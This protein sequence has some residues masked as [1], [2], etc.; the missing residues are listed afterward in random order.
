[1]PSTTSKTPNPLAVRL[2]AEDLAWLRA[3]RETN[4]VSV[5]SLISKAVA[6]Y[7]TRVEAARKGKATRGS[8][9]R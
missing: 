8:H 9:S 5:N 3:E 6:Q 1:M 2:D 7:R 4:G